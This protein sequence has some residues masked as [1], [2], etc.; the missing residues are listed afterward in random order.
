MNSEAEEVEDFVESG[1]GEHEARVKRAADDAA[2][3]V[4]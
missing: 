1:G 4:P 3:G 2:E